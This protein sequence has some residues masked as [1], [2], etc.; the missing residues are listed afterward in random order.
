MDMLVKIIVG[1]GV[2]AGIGGLLLWW[3][4][5]DIVKREEGDK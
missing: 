5:S 3:F 4:V 1:L 2:A